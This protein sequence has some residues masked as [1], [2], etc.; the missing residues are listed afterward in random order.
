MGDGRALW[1]KSDESVVY[2][3]SGG[4][5]TILNKWTPC[6]GRRL[7]PQRLQGTG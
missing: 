6:G 1:V 4:T 3:G 5:A 2:F 7:G